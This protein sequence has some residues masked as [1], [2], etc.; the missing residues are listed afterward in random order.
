MAAAALGLL[1]LA[2]SSCT[3]LSTGAR[4]AIVVLVRDEVTTPQSPQ[5]PM[6]P[7]DEIETCLS[8]HFLWL[9]DNR[10]AAQ[11]IAYIDVRTPPTPL[12]PFGLT[13]RNVEKNPAWDPLSVSSPL[14]GRSTQP[15]VFRILE[16]T[17]SL[18]KNRPSP[19]K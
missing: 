5:L 13:V 10:R 9:E 11:W 19:S 14:P 6:P 17:E 8:R 1:A 16:Q 15:E 7:R 18:E 2:T 12:Q 3:V 4:S